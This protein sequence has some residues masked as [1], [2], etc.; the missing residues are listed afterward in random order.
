MSS[1][2]RSPSPDRQVKDLSGAKP[3]RPNNG[4]TREQEELMA[5]WS[6]IASCYRWMHDR[7]EKIMAKNNMMIT[8]PV[9]ILSTLTG[10]ANFIMG[11]LL[12]GDP[13]GQKYAQI[14]IGGVSI[15][16]GILTTLGN[17]FRYAQSSEAHRVASIAWGKFQRQL[18]VELALHPRERIDC[19]DFLKICRAE[20]DRMIEQS[21]PIPDK[22]IHQFEREFK[23]FKDLKRPDIAHGMDHTKVFIDKDSRLK[24]IAADAAIMIKQKRKVW[25]TAMM[26]DVEAHVSKH[27]RD[28]SGNHLAKIQ[29]KIAQLEAAVEAQA[30]RGK[31]P[32][33]HGGDA[34]TSFRSFLRDSG[35]IPPPSV[36]PERRASIIRQAPPSPPFSAASLREVHIDSTIPSSPLGKAELLDILQQPRTLLGR[37]KEEEKK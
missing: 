21:P 32:P 37:A 23:D 16:T 15:F 14:G 24:Q 26:P 36:K 31:T 3:P 30:A 11:S 5:G 12:E 35:P 29:E 18:A 19:M 1:T 20:L 17:F 28:L 10:S 2:P 27:I 8:V 34:P 13:Q 7:C 6:D 4:W 33:R 22:V 25:H 9:I